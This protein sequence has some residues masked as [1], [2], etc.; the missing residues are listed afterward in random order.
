[1]GWAAVTNGQSLCTGY[2]SS[3]YGFTARFVPRS[4]TS[5]GQLRHW[6]CELVTNRFKRLNKS[7]CPTR[8]AE[9]R[10]CRCG[11]NRAHLYIGKVCCLMLVAR[12]IRN[13]LSNSPCPL[14]RARECG[15]YI[16]LTRAINDR[17]FQCK[18]LKLFRFPPHFVIAAQ[19]NAKVGRGAVMLPPSESVQVDR[20]IALSGGSR[21]V[22]LPGAGRAKAASTERQCLHWPVDSLP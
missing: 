16:L 4:R 8:A 15:R 14:G 18:S 17:P 19:V 22:K 20:E 1:M 5:E 3:C 9:Q 11:E 2:C 21:A 12:G 6:H 10:R 13:S 7:P